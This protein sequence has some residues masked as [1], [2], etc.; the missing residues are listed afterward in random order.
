[1]GH[2]TQFFIG[3]ING[4]SHAGTESISNKDIIILAYL[5]ISHSDFNF[6][7]FQITTLSISA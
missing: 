5:E 6:D 1:M 2:P 3:V 4:Y 7:S